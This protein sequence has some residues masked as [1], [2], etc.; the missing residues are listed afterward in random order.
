MSQSYRKRDRTARLLKLQVLLWQYPQGIKVDEISRRFSTSKRTIYR[1]LLALESE[2]D[3]P[4]WEDSG[5]RGIVEG[6]FLPPVTLTQPEAM[7]IFLAARLMQNYSYVYNPSV[8][9][10]FMKLNTMEKLYMCL[11]NEKPEIILDEQVIEKA[12]KP[13]ERMLEISKRK[14]LIQ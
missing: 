12:R 6:Y 4:I 10:T 9:A 14:N 11:K 5:K 7:N 3:V 1:D 13:I 2:L 8:I